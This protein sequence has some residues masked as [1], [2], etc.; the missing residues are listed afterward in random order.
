MRIWDIAIKLLYPKRIG[1]KQPDRKP[2]NIS[3][4]GLNWDIF[5]FIPS[6]ERKQTGHIAPSVWKT[7]RLA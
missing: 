3:Q 4:I 2:E 6:A 7:Y 5:P 1:L